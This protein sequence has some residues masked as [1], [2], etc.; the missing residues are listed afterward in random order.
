MITDP[1]MMMN[2]PT[3]CEVWYTDSQRGPPLERRAQGAP[4]TEEHAKT[5]APAIGDG[6]REER[7]D[8]VGVSGGSGERGG[9]S[10]TVGGQRRAATREDA[11]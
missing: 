11:A 2:P 4:L 7:A 10:E 9:G 5:T 1:I 6:A 8:L 3:T